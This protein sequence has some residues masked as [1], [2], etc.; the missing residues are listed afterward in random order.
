MSSEP[1]RPAGPSASAA[2]KL[3]ARNRRATGQCRPGGE[4]A[5][6]HA[7]VQDH[8]RSQRTAGSSQVTAARPAHSTAPGSRS[9]RRWPGRRSAD[10]P[11]PAAAAAPRSAPLP[12]PRAPAAFAERHPPPLPL[13][14]PAPLRRRPDRAARRGR[15]WTHAR[16]SRSCS[17]SVPGEQPGKHRRS[18]MLRVSP[19]GRCFRPRSCRLAPSLV[20]H[21]QA[22]GAHEVRSMRPYPESSEWPVT[23]R[24]FIGRRA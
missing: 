17:A 1:A 2:G 19:T 20:H 6:A 5:D 14:A 13:L 11:A 8:R 3:C 21:L 10:P 4:R 12:P 9:A 16:H 24:F 22:R 18:G 7:P 15:W 23:R